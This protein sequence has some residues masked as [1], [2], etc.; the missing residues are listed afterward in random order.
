MREVRLAA[1]R[2][3]FEFLRRRRLRPSRLVQDQKQHPSVKMSKMKLTLLSVVLCGHPKTKIIGQ[4]KLATQ[5]DS[6]APRT[7][8]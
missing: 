7:N 5:D 1:L 3:I 4:T 2:I 6:I 8:E